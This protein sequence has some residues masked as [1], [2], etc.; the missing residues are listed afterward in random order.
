MKKPP[1]SQTSTYQPVAARQD[2]IYLD[3]RVVAGC[4][5]TTAPGGWLKKQARYLKV[6]CRLTTIDEVKQLLAKKGGSELLP[7]VTSRR[8][9]P[10]SCCSQVTLLPLDVASLRLNTRKESV[11]EREAANTGLNVLVSGHLISSLWVSGLMSESI[12]IDLMIN[13]ANNFFE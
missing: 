4:E 6:W 9:R 3:N 13:V 7:F 8:Q 10:L 5:N 1:A 12:N 2:D 11:F